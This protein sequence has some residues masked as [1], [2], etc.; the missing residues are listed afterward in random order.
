MKRA[1]FKCLQSV[2]EHVNER[3][4]V[5]LDNAAQD[6]RNSLPADQHQPINDTTKQIQERWKVYLTKI[7]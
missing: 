6:L 3:W 4:I 5:E 2:L 1:V 7:I